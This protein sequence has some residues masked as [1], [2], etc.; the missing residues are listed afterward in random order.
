MLKS[1]RSSLELVCR[2]FS[3]ELSL[4][5]ALEASSH[6]SPPANGGTRYQ[7]YPSDTDAVAD[8][9]ALCEHMKVK[10]RLYRTGFRGAKV[11]A[12]QTGPISDKTL[13]RAALVE[14]LTE[15]DG[16]LFTGCDLNTDLEDMQHV[17]RSAPFVLAAL[18]SDIDPGRATGEGVVA[19]LVGALREL[20]PRGF[21]TPERF[22]VLGCGATGS[23][24]ARRL[25]DAGARVLTYDIRSE[26]ADIPG[27]ENVSAVPDWASLPHDVLLPC[28][29]SRLI[30][31]HVARRLT[32]RLIVGAS[33]DPITEAAERILDGREI[34]WVPDPVSNAGAVV[35]DSIEHYAS[36]TL[37][38]TDPADVY[39]FVGELLG[40]Q[41]QRLV[42]SSLE[43]RRSMRLLVEAQT[44]VRDIG[45]PCGMSFPAWLDR[46][47]TRE[48]A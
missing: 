42:K 43:D 36:A 22:L 26:R 39:R 1:P 13:L 10:H 7:F 17:Q 9:F 4:F 15:F 19:S 12:R 47:R 18:G 35:V 21:A 37:R 27:C 41:T 33:N 38:T 45:P 6:P 40:G 29:A 14:L 44:E 11:V 34:L 8:A 31:H 5:A 28:S 2:R 48:A 3:E 30:D 46:H 16:R 32:C 23:V 24:V 20:E 25:R